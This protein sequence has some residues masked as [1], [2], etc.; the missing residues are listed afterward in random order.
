MTKEFQSSNDKFMKWVF[1]LVFM[2]QAAIGAEVK[3]LVER[4]V[5][6]TLVKFPTL[7]S[8]EL[9]VTAID[10]GDLQ[11]R[12]SYRGDVPI[13]PASVIKLFYLEAAHRWMEDGKIKDTAELRRAMKDMIVVSYNEATHYVL[14]VLTE[15]TSGP[16]LSAAEMEAW[17]E[18]RNAVNRYFAERGFAGINV[19]QKPW[20]E[21]PYGRDRIFVGEKYTNRNMLTTD[22]TARLML[23]IATLK[24][25]TEAR[26]KEMLKL[27]SREG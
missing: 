23:E 7:K 18:K 9:A 15:T 10:L 26:S 19:N 12:G 25:V 5:A 11:N 1:V 16:E 21:G 3:G 6:E 27:L 20:C 8:N 4:V 24:A 17:S 14:D 2:V 22:A 13:Y